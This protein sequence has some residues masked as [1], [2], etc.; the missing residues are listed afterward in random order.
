MAR[1]PSLAPVVNL[2]KEFA[3][4]RATQVPMVFFEQVSCLGVRNGVVNITLEG[5][6]HYVL[7]GQA[8]DDVQTAGHLRFPVAAIASIRAALDKIEEALKP[9]PPEMK[10]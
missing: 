5:G 6:I 4:L 8:V 10:N 9:V 2:R 3:T 7:E 1:P